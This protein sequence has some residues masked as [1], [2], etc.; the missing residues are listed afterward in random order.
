ML[1]NGY[2]KRVKSIE[3]VNCFFAEVN[4]SKNKRLK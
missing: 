4:S 3:E 2:L 1:K